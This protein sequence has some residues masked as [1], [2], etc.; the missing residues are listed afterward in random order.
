M[1]VLLIFF[2]VIT[3]KEPTQDSDFTQL[4]EYLSIYYRVCFQTVII[5]LEKK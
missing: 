3:H 1:F 4:A 2:I 5:N